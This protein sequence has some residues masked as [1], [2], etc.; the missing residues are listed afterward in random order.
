MKITTTKGDLADA[1][2]IAE[3]WLCI[4]CGVN[5]APGLL[6][7]TDLEKAFVGNDSVEQEVGET[8]EIYTVRDAVWKK[9]GMEEYGGCLCIG[10]LEKRLGRKLKPKDFPNDP[11]NWIPEGTPRLIKRRGYRHLRHRPHLRHRLIS[12][13]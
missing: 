7:R 1:S 4:D 3:S 2:S 12:A 13:K 6:G 11:L 10:C 5:T 9:A 8:T